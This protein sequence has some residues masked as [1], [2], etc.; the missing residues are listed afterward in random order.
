MRNLEERLAALEAQ[1]KK[2]SDSPVWVDGKNNV[3]RVDINRRRGE[4]VTFPS[5]ADAI[6]WIEKQ[7]DTH[8]GGVIT[9]QA[10]NICDLH[11]NGAELRDV[12]RGII[13]DEIIISRTSGPAIGGQ[14]QPMTFDAD[15]LPVSIV[16][17]IIPAGQP[18]DLRLWSLA[19]LITRI[20][21]NRNFRGRW[22]TGQTTEN[23]NQLLLACL[24]IFSWG[25][26]EGLQDIMSDFARLFYQVTELKP[27][28]QCP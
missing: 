15:R 11:K 6:A 9:Y 1:I 10:D 16:L 2:N 28:A 23:D 3:I 19:N 13:P 22:Q 21:E 24:A 4:P 5:S 27:A 12:I 26:P 7:I 14:I 18:A 8:A 17:N 25:K 20:F